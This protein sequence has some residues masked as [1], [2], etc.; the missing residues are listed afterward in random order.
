MKKAIMVLTKYPQPGQVKTRLIPTLGPEGAA[1]LHRRLTQHVVNCAR[2]AA[3]ACC[4]S[5]QL[6]FRGGS[7][8]ELKAWLGE[9][10]TCYPQ[11]GRDLGERMRRAFEKAFQDGALAAVLVGSDLPGLTP[12][13]LVEA[14]EA[15]EKQ[16]VVLGPSTDGGYYLMGL[17]GGEPPDL[18]SGMPWGT[19]H[20]LTR[21]LE[22]IATLGLDARLLESLQD[23]DRPEDLPLAARL[24]P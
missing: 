10:I 22:R 18:F 16:R 21:T 4:A 19:E 11:Q 14:L 9:E 17:E 24:L 7:E 23:I 2:E 12:R 20:V 15:L 5:L 1:F 8:K 6:H 13:I 3:R